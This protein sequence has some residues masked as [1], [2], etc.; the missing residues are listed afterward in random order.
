MIHFLAKGSFLP[1]YP[2]SVMNQYGLKA[3]PVNLPFHPWPV[4]VIP[5]KNRALSPVVE[6]FIECIREIAK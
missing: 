4:V 1:G 5:L 2:R 3:L 6:H